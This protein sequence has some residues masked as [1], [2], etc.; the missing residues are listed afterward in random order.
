MDERPAVPQLDGSRIRTLRKERELTAEA[1]ARSADIST[2]HI[3]RL[4]SNR[5]PNSAA[6]VVARV[7]LALGT[8][9]EYLLGLTDNPSPILEPTADTPL[10]ESV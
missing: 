1:L 9:V 6:V 4:E 10:D 2:R 7:A 8:T 3:W 5:R